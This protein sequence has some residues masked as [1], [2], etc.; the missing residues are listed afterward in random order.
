MKYL[1]VND[2]SCVREAHLEIDRLMVIIG[3]Q[4]SGKS[5]LCKLYYFFISIILEQR[6]SLYERA[7]FEEYKEQVKE[8]FMEWFPPA[9]WGEGKFCIQFQAGEFEIKL[10]RTSYRGGTQ[11]NFKIKL[12]EIVEAKYNL[13]LA[14][15]VA[16]YK[17]SEETE[18]EFQIGFRAD[19][20]ITAYIKG[21]MGDEYIATQ[22]FI[23]AG[24][25]FFTSIG[26]AM[27]FF[28]HG[29][30]LDPII[31]QFGRTFANVK[32]NKGRVA[33]GTTAEMRRAAESTAKAMI[34]IFGGRLKIERDKEYVVADDGRHVPLP[35]LSSGQ[36][37]LLPLLVVLPW[38]SGRPNARRMLYIEEPEAHLFPEA[39]SDLV[40]VLTDIVNRAKST[41]LVVTTHS[42]YVL[43]KINNLVK[44]GILF[45][46]H[47]PGIREALSQV[48]PSS[49]W[50]NP[51][52]ITAYAI[53]DGVVRDIR[54]ESGLIDA[55]YLDQVSGE[56][57]KEFMG[58]L[59]LEA[60][61]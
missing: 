24:R 43:S 25:S 48:I 17:R 46:E 40:E 5:I 61:L 32:E 34:R 18:D 42:P 29:R 31:L 15:I 33:L 50:I 52:T 27:A 36:Q 55:D 51:N 30:M 10:N 54:D 22:T 28:E 21:Q 11:D 6:A 53:V 44:A 8:K 1:S 12:P 4:A 19:E 60:M 47:G 56:I 38:L 26:K 9:A 39:Q 37:E 16:M 14:N 57:S 13:A 2:F 58:L 23:P 7:S 49:V 3:P 41:S 20:V 59:K 45:E 35:S